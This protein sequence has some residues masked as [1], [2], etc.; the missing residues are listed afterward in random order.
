[1]NVSNF[2]S[3]SDARRSLWAAALAGAG[4]MAGV[5]EIVFHQLLQWHHFFDRSTPMIGIVSDGLLHAAELLAIVIGVI[6]LIDLSQR[7]RLAKAWAWS[8]FFL[9]MGGFQLFDGI[10]SHKILRIHQIRYGVDP[11]LY[12]LTWNAAAVVLLLIGGWLY[13][14]AKR[15]NPV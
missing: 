4:I 11:L 12:D 13:H 15:R 9:G 3:Q 5:D 2:F 6:L 14:R 8:G 10:V 1:M 7:K